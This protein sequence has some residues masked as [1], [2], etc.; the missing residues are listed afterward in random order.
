MHCSGLVFYLVVVFFATGALVASALKVTELFEGLREK[1]EVRKL[2][3]E[4]I[5]GPNKNF[6]VFW[7]RMLKRLLLKRFFFSNKSTLKG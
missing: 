6:T 5:N 2:F 3:V 1:I 7:K 4:N